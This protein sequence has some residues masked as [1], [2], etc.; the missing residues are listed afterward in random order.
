MAMTATSSRKKSAVVFQQ[1][2]IESL[3]IRIENTVSLDSDINSENSV[4][5]YALIDTLLNE[6][7]E[8]LFITADVTVISV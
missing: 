6:N 2:M 1:Q 4:D 3:D 5:A 8:K 7:E